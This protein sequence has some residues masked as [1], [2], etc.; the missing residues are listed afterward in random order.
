MPRKETSTRAALFAV[1]EA[2]KNAE[3]L[4]VKETQ[5]AR[6]QLTAT[7]VTCRSSA[8]LRRALLHACK[9]FQTSDTHDSSNRYLVSKLGFCEPCDLLACL[10]RRGCWN[11]ERPRQVAVF[12]QDF[13]NVFRVSRDQLACLFVRGVQQAASMPMPALGGPQ[14][15]KNVCYYWDCVL[16]WIMFSSTPIIMQKG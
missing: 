7:V 14:L 5:A 3:A 1:L 13:C 10:W 2:A 15:S 12:E 11:A 16:F 8:M 4:A 9:Y 6:L